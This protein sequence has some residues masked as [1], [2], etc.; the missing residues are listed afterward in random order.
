MNLNNMSLNSIISPLRSL[1]DELVER[2]LWPIAIVLVVALIAVPVVL[3]KPAKEAAPPP[4]I[5]AGTGAG[6]PG[7][8][9][10]PAVTTDGMKSSQIRKRLRS[11][12]RKNPFTPQGLSAGG[13]G[14]GGDAGA[15]TVNLNGATPI[16]PT[17]SGASTGSLTDGSS[18]TGGTEQSGGSTGSGGTTT[19]TFYYHY[20]VDV[21]FGKTDNPDTKTLTEFRALP[22]SDNPIVV[23]M[24]VKN[25]GK[26]AVFLVTADASTLGDGTCSPTD[27]E[28]TFLYL[29]KDDK[30][31][32]EAVDVD[33]GIT[34]YVLELLSV[35]VRRTKGPEKATSSQAGRTRLRAENRSRL[36]RV[37]NSFRAL[38]L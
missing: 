14:G 22:S 25:D 29:Q 13:G 19:E 27:T 5:A 16:S 35:D 10:Q 36:R 24:G 1:W 23:F 32:I 26:T 37:E 30:Q 20:T 11:F 31:T 33:G 28:C 38:G 21:K 4:P 6:S 17:D 3:S 15:A 7:L 12:K 2:R 34:S 9:F 8:A 18:T